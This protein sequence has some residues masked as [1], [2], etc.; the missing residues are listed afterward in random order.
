MTDRQKFPEIT[1]QEK[2]KQLEAL[3]AEVDII[4]AEAIINQVKTADFAIHI[5]VNA[6][7]Q[8]APY[9][10]IASRMIHHSTNFQGDEMLQFLRF[11]AK[12]TLKKDASIAQWAVD[13]INQG[14]IINN[15]FKEDNE[16]GECEMQNL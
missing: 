8:K 5:W 6:V 4:L 15:T 12:G 13:L 7:Q 3:Q 9:V 16:N 14:L 11:L 10:A 1:L 2:Q